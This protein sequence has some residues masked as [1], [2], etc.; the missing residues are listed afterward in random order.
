MFAGTT[1]A[2]QQANIGSMS[3]VCW[4]T[5][6]NKHD[7]LNQCCFNVGPASKTVAQH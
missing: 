1:A 2:Q 4:G 3:R 5:Y 7:T 6:P